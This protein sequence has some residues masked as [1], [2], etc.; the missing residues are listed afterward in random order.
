MFDD[1]LKPRVPLWLHIAVGVFLGTVGANVATWGAAAWAAKLTAQ[2]A[3][4]Q[5]GRAAQQ[6]RQATDAEQ[7]ARVQADTARRQQAANQQRAVE[8]QKQQAE[9]EKE[10]RELAWTRFYRKPPA[11]DESKGGA[12][13]VDCANDYIRAKARFADLYDAGKL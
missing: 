6:R 7:A 4:E 10:R 3:A 11:C 2:E 1:H 13:T 8:Q 9:A 12:W 5:L